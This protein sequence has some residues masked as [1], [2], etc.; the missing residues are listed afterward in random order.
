VTSAWLDL[1]RIWETVQY[2][3]IS[4]CSAMLSVRW[5]YRYARRWV[6]GLCL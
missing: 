1:W 2:C 6:D 5:W 4:H 3:H